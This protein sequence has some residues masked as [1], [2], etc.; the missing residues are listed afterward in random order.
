MT[1]KKNSKLVLG[2]VQFGTP[3]GI[4]NKKKKKPSKLEVKR[5]LKYAKLNKINQ[6]DNSEDYN[7]D[8]KNINKLN[9]HYSTKIRNSTINNSIKYFCIYIHDGDKFLKNKDKSL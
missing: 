6:L 9:F 3:Y 8:F 5:I 7:F 2:C 1:R 4:Q